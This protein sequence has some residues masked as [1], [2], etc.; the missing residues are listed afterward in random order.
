MSLPESSS[1]QPRGVLVRKPVTTIY[2]TLLLIALIALVISC[3]IM[4]LE[5]F[6]YGLQYKPPA[7]LRSSHI[8]VVA[9]YLI[10]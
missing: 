8:P 7:N 3:A 9:P 10:V 4:A 5:M 6:Q 2:T 1:E